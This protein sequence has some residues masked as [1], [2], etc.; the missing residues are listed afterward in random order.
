MASGNLRDPG[1]ATHRV[2]DD[3]AFLEHQ[4]LAAGGLFSDLYG[5]ET[6][7]PD[8]GAASSKTF[9]SDPL[10]KSNFPDTHSFRTAASLFLARKLLVPKKPD[11]GAYLTKLASQPFL[12]PAFKQTIWETVPLLFAKGWD[13]KYSRYAHLVSLARKSTVECKAKEGGAIGAAADRMSFEEFHE[14]L[15]TGRPIPPERDVAVIERDGK[16]RIVTVASFLQHQLLPLHLLMYDHIARKPWILRGEAKASK[17]SSFVRKKG[18]VFVSGDYESATDNFSSAVS[19]EVLKAVLF[20]A[21]NVPAGI[22]EAASDSLQGFLWYENTF[23]PQ[24][25]GQLMGN[26]LSFPLL[27][28]VNYLTVVHAFG[29]KKANQLPLKINGDDIVF[30]CTRE[31]FDRWAG[32]VSQCG[33]KLSIG[34]TLLHSFYFSIN[35]RFFIAC[36]QRAKEIAV[37]RLHTIFRK[38]DPNEDVTVVIQGRLRAATR[39]F[40]GVF[41]RKI[42]KAFLGFHRKVIRSMPCS[43]N[44]G[45]GVRV[46]MEVLTDTDTLDH[47]LDRLSLMPQLDVPRVR[48]ALTR[49]N[50][51]SR[52][53]LVERA[54]SSVCR[55]CRVLQS[56]VIKRL[57][58]RESWAEASRVMEEKRCTDD[59]Q[60]RG[61]SDPVSGLALRGV[62]LSRAQLNKLARSGRSWR[63]YR[64]W[65]NKSFP[66]EAWD[67][68]WGRKK[69]VLSRKPRTL[70]VREKFLCFRCN[71]SCVD[72]R[73]SVV[74][75]ARE[76]VRGEA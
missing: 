61:G 48:E 38:V 42:V 20:H 24:R 62:R 15:L 52:Y 49:Q 66:R 65:R 53:S 9:F 35:S 37:L 31:D 57:S 25:N 11:I 16:V 45:L 28:I 7:F 33:L 72:V 2:H 6:P 26:Y 13:R 29:Y 18:E 21:H 47:E 22:K 74:V 46:P 32:V 30:R 41:R 60:E 4:R 14:L 40:G 5:L 1:S 19:T 55:G 3:V 36:D 23:F 64:H 27:C 70:Y 8:F 69:R 75:G 54:A 68:I 17:F 59:S 34:K 58:N 56:Q 50:V 73:S 71:A 76:F 10:E 67:W 51:I 44:R 12:D 63:S 43:L 39:G